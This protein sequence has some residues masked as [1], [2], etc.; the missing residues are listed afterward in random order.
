[1]ET[2]MNTIRPCSFQLS[3]ATD[4]DN[5]VQADEEHGELAFK[6]ACASPPAATLSVC[7][8]LGYESRR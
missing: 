3:L 6:E 4:G 1:M 5:S 7:P 8:G 2:N